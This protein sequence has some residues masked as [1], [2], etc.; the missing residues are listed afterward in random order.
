MC[1]SAREMNE[2]EKKERACCPDMPLT[3][4]I[5]RLGVSFAVL[6]FRPTHG[7]S[8]LAC[9]V[10]KLFHR[11][12]VFFRNACQFSLRSFTQ[13]AVVTNNCNKHGRKHNYAVSLGVVDRFLNT[14]LTLGNCMKA[15]KTK[16]ECGL[17]KKRLKKLM[18]KAF[19]WSMVSIKSQ[20]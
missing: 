1:V 19:C 7:F 8:R 20:T 15:C 3:A 16:P 12:H 11:G 2:W 5:T 9:R 13:T 18:T 4:I 10:T 6:D 14:V 17:K